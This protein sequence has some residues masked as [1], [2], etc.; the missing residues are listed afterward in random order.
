PR[1]LRWANKSGQAVFVIFLAWLG[2]IEL[3]AGN[4]TFGADPMRDYFALLAWGFGAEL[5]RESVVRAAQ[6]LGVSLT[7]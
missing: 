3:Y 1:N 5:T 4:T 7:K 2:M 6:D